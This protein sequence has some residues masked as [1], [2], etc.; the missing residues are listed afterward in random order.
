MRLNE[1]RGYIPKKCFEIPAHGKYYTDRYSDV[2][3]GIS[4]TTT[5]TNN[6][7]ISN[8]YQDQGFKLKSEC[9][10]LLER[11]VI[12]LCVQACRKMFGKPCPFC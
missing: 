6:Y 5:S 2:L 9:S 8:Q 3:L 7:N 4:G 10:Q 11:R 12:L 1:K